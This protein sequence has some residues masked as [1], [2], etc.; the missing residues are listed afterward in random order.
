MRGTMRGKIRN[1]ILFIL[2]IAA[3]NALALPAPQGHVSDFANVLSGDMKYR[4]ESLAASFQTET[5][6]E[7]A[8]VTVE[9]LDDQ[10]VEN[11][12]FDLYQKWGIG[13]KGKDNGILIL[14]APNERKIR[15]EVGYGLEPIIN[16]AVAG[17]IIRETMIPWFKN[18]DYNLGILNGLSE[19]IQIISSKEG[20]SFDVGKAAGLNK[21]LPQLRHT[22]MME[23][24]KPFN[25]LQGIG[26]LIFLLFFIPFFIRHPFLALFLLS[27]FGGGRRSSGGFGGGFGGFG[28][29]SSGGGGA[30]GRW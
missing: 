5:G 25:W 29:G 27:G 26:T 7:I 11:Y 14:V 15:I 1:I 21:G 19:T 20:L 8:V 17:R 4:I 12:T 22:G 30:S 9:S 23:T 2:L 3:A 6:N 16:D 13:K 28:G 18:N 24:K 10:P